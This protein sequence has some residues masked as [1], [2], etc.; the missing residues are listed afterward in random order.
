MAN[1]V[2]KVSDLDGSSN[3]NYGVVL[4]NYP[5]VDGA[6]LL[7]VTSEQAEALLNL[8]VKDSVTIE[9]RNPDGSVSAVQVPI[10]ALKKWVGDDKVVQNAAHLKGRRPGFSPTNGH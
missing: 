8:A 3:A 5:G 10:A 4:R 1:V 6:K 7:D 2:S 9:V